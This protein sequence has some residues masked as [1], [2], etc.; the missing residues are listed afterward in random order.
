MSVDKISL[1]F[2][3]LSIV[4]SYLSFKAKD[5]LELIIYYTILN[6]L[7]FLL[8]GIDRMLYI[9]GVSLS[10]LG[11]L[12]ITL[13][14]SK[15]YK[16]YSFLG[17]EGLVFKSPKL[18]FFLRLLSISL[19]GSPPFLNSSVLYL[20]IFYASTYVMMALI[21]LS[22]FNFVVFVKITQNLLF[23]KPNPHLTYKDIDNKLTSLL[24]VVVFVNLVY[25]VV[26][27]FNLI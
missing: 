17:L 11:L 2:L 18:A 1:G 23:G 5:L 20:N 21:T 24:S 7:S 26:F 15:T 19:G 16:S 6:V 4:F 25:G 12:A 13:W 10:V 3:I 22:I 9:V 27:L 14:I 8:I